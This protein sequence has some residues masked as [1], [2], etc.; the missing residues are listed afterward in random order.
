MAVLEKHM[1]IITAK[2][3]FI[4]TIGSIEN[5][6][7]VPQSIVVITNTP[8]ILSCTKVP[9]KPIGRAE[10]ESHNDVITSPGSQDTLKRKQKGEGTGV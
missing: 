4:C 8:A 5:I 3:T 6:C 2:H 9:T 7:T 1:Q 10:R